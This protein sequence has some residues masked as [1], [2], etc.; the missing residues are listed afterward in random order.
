MIERYGTS[1]GT[2]TAIDGVQE[3]RGSPRDSEMK[4][5]TERCPYVSASA[6]R[7]HRMGGRGCPPGESIPAASE[8]K[9]RVSWLQGS[10]ARSLGIAGNSPRTFRIRATVVN[11]FVVSLS[12]RLGATPVRSGPIRYGDSMR[13]DL[14]HTYLNCGA[15]RAGEMY[16]GASRTSTLDRLWDGRLRITYAPNLV[17]RRVG[18]GGSSSR[19]GDVD[20]TI[21]HSD[22]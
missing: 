5:S 7:L 4:T 12:G 14:R 2:D 15:V 17:H 1:R 22:R 10:F 6:D 18:N 16:Q 8:P 13:F 3:V 9:A 20:G 11:P 19:R 21:M